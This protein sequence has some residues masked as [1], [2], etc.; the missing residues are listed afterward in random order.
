MENMMEN[1]SLQFIEEEYEFLDI[2]TIEIEEGDFELYDIEVEDDHTFCITKDNIISHNCNNMV[3][4]CTMPA[5]VSNCSMLFINHVYDDP[6]A[7][8][9]SK[10]KNQSGG[11]G[12]QYMGSIGLQCDK[13]LDKTENEENIGYYRGSFLKFIS[14]KN[15]IV[16]PFY[17]TEVFVDFNHG[18]RKYDGLIEPALEY[19][20]IKEGKK[21]Y[22]VIPSWDEEK[23]IKKT[24]LI[25]PE[26]DEIWDTFLDDFNKKSKNDMSYS[27]IEEMEK[28]DKQIEDEIEAQFDGI[29]VE[30]IKVD[31]LTGN[32][33]SE[34]PSKNNSETE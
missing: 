1:Q 13:R 6:S 7:M 18:I 28:I 12:L 5:L 24:A 15:R 30:E 33:I 3:K 29:E 21:G 14:T 32:E 20:F 22:Y 8:Y 25:L 26:Y 10:V 2:D 34:I 27:S 19:G 16:K 23:Q 31:A 4:G 17:E 11:K 9:A